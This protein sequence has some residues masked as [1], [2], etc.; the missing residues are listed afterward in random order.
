MWSCSEVVSREPGNGSRGNGLRFLGVLIPSPI[1]R[2]PAQ[3]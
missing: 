2:H 1:S 3:S